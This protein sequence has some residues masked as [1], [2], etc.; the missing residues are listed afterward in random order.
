M[1]TDTHNLT[2]DDRRALPSG[3][4]V[5][6]RR[7]YMLAEQVGTVDMI[8][9]A[10]GLILCDGTRVAPGDFCRLIRA[11]PTP[12]REGMEGTRPR[13]SEAADDLD[14]STGKPAP[15]FSSPA[16]GP[17]LPQDAPK[18]VE[19]PKTPPEEKPR[20]RWGRALASG[21]VGR[22]RRTLGPAVSR[23]SPRALG[24]MSS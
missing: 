23:S 13:C 5:S 22:F 20:R 1:P 2:T 17:P 24:T 8:G 14:D 3:A 19:P 21:V 16:S 6:Y 11:T 15:D 4:V 12:I 18:G 10:G 7:D 9:S